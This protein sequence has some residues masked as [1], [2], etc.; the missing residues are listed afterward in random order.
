MQLQGHHPSMTDYRITRPENL[1]RSFSIQKTTTATVI[2][3]CHS[4]HVAKLA[5]MG[6][7]GGTDT[8]T[9]LGPRQNKRY[10]IH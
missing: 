2:P 10:S 8:L 9:F 3:A 4:M 5:Y 1:P 7:I 6:E